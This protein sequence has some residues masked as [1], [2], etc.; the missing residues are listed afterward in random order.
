MKRFYP[1]SI[2]FIGLLL[3][4]F[5]SDVSADEVDRVTTFEIRG[6]RLRMQPDEVKAI[7]GKAPYYSKDY[8]KNNVAMSGFI[9]NMKISVYLTDEPYGSGVFDITYRKYPSAPVDTSTFVTYLKVN[10]R[11]KYGN[12]SYEVAAK[13]QEYF[14]CW[15]KS[16]KKGIEKL[17]LFDY[18]LPLAA[19][20]LIPNDRYLVVRFHNGEVVEFSLFDM[21]PLYV[22][23]Q[24]EKRRKVERDK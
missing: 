19:N 18:K 7:M 22:Q 15:S 3:F 10:L 8:K 16:C 14:A 20:K 4:P 17:R 1:F 12:P 6:I 24:E 21:N 5:S 2:L 11:N 9:S 23:Y 13:D